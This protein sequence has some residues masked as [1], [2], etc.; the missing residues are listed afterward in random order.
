MEKLL[1][2]VPRRQTAMIV[3]SSGGTQRRSRVWVSLVADIKRQAVT[4][5]KYKSHRCGVL[6]EE[7]QSK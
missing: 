5:E 6:L 7:E 2:V 1:V 4:S 3:R